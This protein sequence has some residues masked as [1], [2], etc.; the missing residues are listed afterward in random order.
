LFCAELLI[1]SN[2]NSI[3]C[4]QWSLYQDYLVVAQNFHGLS[5]AIKFDRGEDGSEVNAADHRIPLSDLQ[6]NQS[7]GN[8]ILSE[9]WPVAF[10]YD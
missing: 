5:V 3:Y 7:H 10:G 8:K 9:V 2:I 1:V 4:Y 6:N